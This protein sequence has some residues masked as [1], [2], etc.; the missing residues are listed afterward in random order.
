[1]Y[2]T[3]LDC[4]LES[5]KNPRKRYTLIQSGAD[6]E[7]TNWG[8]NFLNLIGDISPK[9]SKFFFYANP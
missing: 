1:M 8:A 3:M 9:K 4:A 6:T 2:S 7:L 5:G